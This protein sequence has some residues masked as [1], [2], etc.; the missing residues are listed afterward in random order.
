[1]TDL[2]GLQVDLFEGRWCASVTRGDVVRVGDV[3]GF[4]HCFGPR[5]HLDGSKYLETSVLGFQVAAVGVRGERIRE[6]RW[7]GRPEFRGSLAGRIGVLAGGLEQTG[8][9]GC[10][11]RSQCWCRGTDQSQVDLDSSGQ[12]N[13]PAHPG[14]I[15]GTKHTLVDIGGTDGTGDINDN[16]KT[17]NRHDSKSLPGGQLQVPNQWHGK[18][19]THEIGKDVDKTG[20]ENG[21]AIVKASMGIFGL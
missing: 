21:G 10:H 4:V 6:L 11:E 15:V 9:E 2:A 3:D 13:R 14:R 1:M 17:E 7:T 20:G 5:F 12:Q 16:T 19:G 18:D 8:E